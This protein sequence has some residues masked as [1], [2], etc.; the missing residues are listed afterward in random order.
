MYSFSILND[1]KIKKYFTNAKF[2]CKIST[3]AKI[4]KLKQEKMKKILTALLAI[5]LL[6]DI[7][8]KNV[9]NYPM[10]FD[11]ELEKTECKFLKD[12][13]I[14]GTT[15][16]TEYS[17]RNITAVWIVKESGFSL[18]LTNKTKST[19]SV[20]WNDGAYM[21]YKGRSS[22]IVTG[23]TVYRD[24]NNSI[25]S[26]K[27]ISNATLSESIIPLNNIGDVLYYG[28]WEIL[29]LIPQPDYPTNTW[30]LSNKMEREKDIV[31]TDFM[32]TKAEQFIKDSKIIVVLPVETEGVTYEYTFIF[33]IKSIRYR[34]MKVEK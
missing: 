25:P 15:N 24:R 31:Y 11:I 20:I 10:F 16:G 3:F 32:N 29:P 30:W 9:R 22:R 7:T 8:A 17:D 21:D 27:V 14:V 12:S 18:S 5:S 4:N 6:T 19:M 1:A 23:S 34:E 33:G 28:T 2:F 13:S 26:S